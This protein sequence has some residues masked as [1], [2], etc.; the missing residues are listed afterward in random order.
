M[1]GLLIGQVNEMEGFFV[2]GYLR[3]LG[4]TFNIFILFIIAV[5][6][7]ALLDIPNKKLIGNGLFLF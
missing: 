1:E 6:S 2:S 7:S 5:I 3:Y 4:F